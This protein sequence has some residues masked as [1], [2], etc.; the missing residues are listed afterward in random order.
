MRLNLFY[1]LAAAA[2][3][4]SGIWVLHLVN[5]V[6][7]ALISGGLNLGSQ[8]AQEGSEGDFSGISTL[9]A[10]QALQ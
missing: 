8:L 6:S 9:L 10:G 5:N 1:L 3:L 7:R 2:P 4:C